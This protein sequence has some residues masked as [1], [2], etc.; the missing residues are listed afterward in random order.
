MPASFR[1]AD[2]RHGPS[3]IA[4]T[5]FVPQFPNPVKPY[6]PLTIDFRNRLW[7]D[8]DAVFQD[9]GLLPNKGGSVPRGG[10]DAVL[11]VLCFGSAGRAIWDGPA[12][13]IR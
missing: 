2:V 11:R 12:T 13:A 8:T 10:G 5:S 3:G 9:E 7:L 1:L 4:E 6:Y